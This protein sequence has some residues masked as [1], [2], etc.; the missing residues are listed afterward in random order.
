MNRVAHGLEPGRSDPLGLTGSPTGRSLPTA[1]NE[2]TEVRAGDW[3]WSNE[4]ELPSKHPC[5][6]QV[7]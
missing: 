6:P 2:W 5:H 3:P 4:E 7:T 1:R